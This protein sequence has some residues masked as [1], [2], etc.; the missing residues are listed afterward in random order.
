MKY[1]FVP[2]SNLSLRPGHFWGIPLSNGK[3]ACGRV[4]QLPPADYRYGKKTSFFAGLM[5]WVSQELPRADTLAGSKL[6]IQGVAHIKTIAA[7]GS[8]IIG[9][10]PLSEDHIEIT[11]QT[12]AAC[13]PCKVVQGFKAV[14]PATSADFDTLT[15]RSVWGYDVVRLAAERIFVEGKSD[16]FGREIER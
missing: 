15:S 3:F 8:G 16:V 12:D 5:D 2:K 7:T 13:V 14:R 9:E 1:P 10:R 11:L 4:L 6:L